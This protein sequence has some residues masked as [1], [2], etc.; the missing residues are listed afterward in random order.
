MWTASAEADLRNK[1][2]KVEK[3]EV[4]VKVFMDRI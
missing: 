3:D 4:H 1:K 2:W